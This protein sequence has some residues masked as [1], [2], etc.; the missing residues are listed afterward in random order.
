MRV[1]RLE[2]F[3]PLAQLL[4]GSHVSLQVSTWRMVRLLYLTHP[5]SLKGLNKKDPNPASLSEM[6]LPKII[7]KHLAFH[8]LMLIMSPIINRRD[9]SFDVR[10]FKHAHMLRESREDESV[11]YVDSV[12]EKLFPR[13]KTILLYCSREEA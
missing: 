1:L 7:A 2:L 3:S 11:F 12:A 6:A 13:N 10:L 9:E 5:T 4:E 8:P